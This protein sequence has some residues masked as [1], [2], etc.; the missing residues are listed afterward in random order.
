MVLGVSP[1]SVA[2]QAKFRKKYDLPFTLLAD[3]DHA[4]AEA[5]GVWQLKKFLGKQYM[6]VTRSTFIIDTSGGI[7]HTYPKVSDAS[8][9]PAEVERTLEELQAA[10][11][12]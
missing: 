6:G 7:A 11:A 8:T 12:R 3:T 4:I 5:Y 10:S 1:D 2:R 9:H